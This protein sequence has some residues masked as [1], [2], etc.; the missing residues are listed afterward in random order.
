MVTS[1]L[2][3]EH[4]RESIKEIAANGGEVFAVGSMNYISSLLVDKPLSDI[5][6]NVLNHFLKNGKGQK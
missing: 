2:F 6:K 4:N 3:A 5:T 1:R